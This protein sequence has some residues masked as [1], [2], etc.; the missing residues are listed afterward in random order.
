MKKILIATRNKDKFKIVSK[1]LTSKLFKGYKCYSIS[2]LKETIDEKKETG[3]I[4]N[5]AF[6]KAKNIFDNLKNN[7][8]DYIIGIDDGIEMKGKIIENVKDY[9]KLII[10]NKYLEENELIYI[11]RA[12]S[13]IKNNGDNYSIFTKIPFKYKKLEY[14]LN[15]K[16]NSYPL[17]HVMMPLNSNKT[18]IEQNDSEANNYY[19]KYS[20]KEFD[21]VKVFFDD[22]HR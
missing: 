18:V 1:L 14:K 11:T 12:Y 9:I 20:E 6:E 16:E 13:F 22:N 7:D 21:S 10:E 3:N 5:R 19:L 17:S 2:N 8:F 15:I 4:T